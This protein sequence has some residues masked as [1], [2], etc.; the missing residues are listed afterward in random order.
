MKPKQ[1]LILAGLGALIL[2]SVL[3]FLLDPAEIA[4]ESRDRQ[5]V[6]DLKQLQKALDFH[7]TKNAKLASDKEKI[8]CSDCS[9]EEDVFSYREISIDT[10]K[11]KAVASAYVNGQGWLPVDLSL[12]VKLGETP[13]ETLPIDPLEKGYNIRQKFPLIN[14]FYSSPE[15][16]VYT[17]TPGKNG[18]YKLT[19]KME[20]L[21]GL[22]QASEDKGSLDDRLEVGSDLSLKP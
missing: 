12:N 21:R 20:S 4:R 8:L 7:L 11:T 6:E 1:I 15:D 10:T 3:V 13:L 18:K 2:S 9:L 16:F 22:Q 17:F 19:A 14:N 5:R